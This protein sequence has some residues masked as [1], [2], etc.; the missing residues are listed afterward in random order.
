MSAAQLREQV[1]QVASQQ[2]WSQA[3]A[4]AAFRE[5]MA[6][7]S[8]AQ[9]F[10]QAM[11]GQQN[12]YTQGLGAEQWAQKQHE[13]YATQLYDRQAQQAQQAYGVGRVQ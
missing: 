13:A 9:N 3:Q 2:G 5:Q 10:G 8:Q 6:Q 11:A 12:A 1:N 4:E 7:Q